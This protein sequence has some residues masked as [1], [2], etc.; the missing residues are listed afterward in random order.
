MTVSQL[1][2]QL[3]E[4]VAFEARASEFVDKK[5]RVSAR[6]TISAL[7]NAVSAAERRNENREAATQVWVADLVGII[8]QS[9]GKGTGI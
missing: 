3:I 6:L 8:P 5:K 1:I 4:Q 7:E 9:P 2:K